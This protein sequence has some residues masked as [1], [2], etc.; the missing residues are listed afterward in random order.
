MDA[1]LVNDKRQGLRADARRNRENILKA[2]VRLFACQGVDASLDEIARAARVGPGTLYRHFPTREALLAA[3][4]MDNQ[5]ELLGRAD[6]ARKL[7]DC[8]SALSAWLGALQAY[9]RSYNGLPVPVLATI[10]KEASPQALSCDMLISLTGEFLTRAQE[11]GRVRASVSADDLFL[12]VL[13][14]AWV[15]NRAGLDEARQKA[16]EAIITDGYRVPPVSKSR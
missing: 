4:L 11:E 10:E 13:G 8:D 7:T 15:V 12:S 16:L 9:L 2:A 5:A 6:A 1:K 14:A 3:A